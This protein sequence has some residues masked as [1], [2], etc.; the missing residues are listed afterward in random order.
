M[1]LIPGT[2]FLIPL[3]LTF[4]AIN[5]ATGI[6]LI[7][8]NAGAVLLYTAFFLPLSLFILRGF[9]AAIPDSSPIRRTRR[10]C[11]DSKNRDSSLSI[12]ESP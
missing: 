7:G 9:F 4:L 1:Q 11:T 2:L 3:F 5:N 10:G 8:S 6:P 12:L